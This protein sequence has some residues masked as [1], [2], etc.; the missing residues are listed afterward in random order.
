[1]KRGRKIWIFITIVLII[2]A[3][4]FGIHSILKSSASEKQS[5]LYMESSMIKTDFCADS[6]YLFCYEQCEF[7]PRIMNSTAHDDCAEYL[8]N[9]FRDYGLKVTEQDAMLDGYDGT[10][11]KVKNIIASI[12][13]DSPKRILICAHWDSRPWADNDPMES[14]HKKP[15]MAANDGASGIAVMLEIAR[16]SSVDSCFMSKIKFGIDFICFDAEDWG[17]PQWEEEDN[18]DSWALGS[19]Y[20]ANHPHRSG[21]TA[22][23][24]ILLDMVGG[25]GA[26]FY[27]E[28][29][30]DYYAS[31][32][33][34]KVW[35]V[36]NSIGYGNYFINS[37]GGNVTDDHKPINEILHIPTIDIVPYYPDCQSS[38]FGPTWHTTYDTMDNIDKDVLSAVGAT[39][40]E[41][42]KNIKDE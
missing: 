15:V 26:R 14:N 28:G 1:M 39:L 32:I 11:L 40:L 2:A 42:I 3:V 35:S 24:G 34:D 20:W 16:L 12:N 10:P 13:P 36:A 30:S 17:T 18:P 8:I 9:K 38:S 41:V 29:F 27:R 23:F 6:A 5:D 21:Y 25:K 37:R 33:V 7:G 4:T 19:Q 31:G 22:N